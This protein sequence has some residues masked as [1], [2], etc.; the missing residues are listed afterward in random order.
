M[1]ESLKRHIRMGTLSVGGV[2]IDWNVRRRGV[3]K[4]D[5]AALESSERPYRLHLGPGPNWTKPDAHWINVD[6]DP[7][8]GDIVLDFQDFSGFPIPDASVDAVYGSHVFEHMSIWVTDLVFAEIRRVLAP[9]G[10]LRIVIPDVETSI[11]EYLRGNRDFPLFQRR[12]ARA[13]ERYGLEYTLFD[14][15]REDFLSRSGQEGLLGR[16]ALAHQNAWDFESLKAA[17]L[18]AGFSD[19]TKSAYQSSNCEM[20]SFEGK[21]E[22]EAQEFDRSLYV[23]AQ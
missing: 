16:G 8:W 6:V 12:R 10:T 18:R 22:S 15:L 14:C 9:G 21:Y 4:G 3:T 2:A 1:F 7:R 20:F 5:S 17:L 23:D 11:R 13:L 19:V